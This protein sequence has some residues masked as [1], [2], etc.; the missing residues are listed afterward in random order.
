MESI[1]VSVV[2]IAYNSEKTILET[3]NSINKQT[4]KNIEIIICDDSSQDNTIK[5]CTEW[6]TKQKIKN[7]MIL[8][9]IN[10][11][12]IAKNINKGLKK[13][14]GKWIKLIAAD[15]ILVNDC[16]EK[17]LN[18]INENKDVNI[19]FSK[20]EKFYSTSNQII[21]F[22][23]R[24]NNFFK[25]T[26]EEQYKQL[27]KE[28]FVPAPSSFI[29]KEIFQKYGYFDERIPM[30]E[31]WPYWLKIT[32][33][34]EKL[35]YFDEVTVKYRIGDTLSNNMTRLIN[36]NFLNS[37]FL[38]YK[39]YLRNEVGF[40]LKYHYLFEYTSQMYLAKFFNNK[41]NK[42][43]LITF[44]YIKIFDFCFIYLRLKEFLKKEKDEQ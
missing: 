1:L 39:Y 2:V 37:K 21:G 23:P 40:F 4:Y 17:N 18:F 11:E 43:S 15:D 32:L 8:E 33:A 42:F 20:I 29:K 25:L 35:Y 24:K 26:S 19:C 27:Q 5:I 13:V 16:I 30:I 44:K 9:S 10:N 14:N 28:C 12:G 6:K 38:I 36:Y 31:D 34:G 22:L 41:R 7:V 3:L